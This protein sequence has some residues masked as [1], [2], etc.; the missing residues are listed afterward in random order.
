MPPM[1]TV[2]RFFRLA[3]K[4][5]LRDYEMIGREVTFAFYRDGH[6]SHPGVIETIERVMPFT[7]DIE[8][9]EHVYVTHN[10]GRVT[11][12]RNHYLSASWLTVAHPRRLL[13]LALV[14][15]EYPR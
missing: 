1:L 12:F 3:D 10:Q 8:D 2:E 13:A 9:V 4:L 14:R 15:R 11:L 6:S 7:G 5:G